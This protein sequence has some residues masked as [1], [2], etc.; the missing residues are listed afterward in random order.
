MSKLF[1]E[2]DRELLRHILRNGARVK[3][4]NTIAGE[5]LQRLRDLGVV[6]TQEH[7]YVRCAYKDD[8][9]F[10]DRE[11][12]DCPGRIELDSEDEDYYCPDCGQPIGD[13]ERKTVFVEYEVRLSPVGIE[14]YLERVL[15]SLEVVEAVEKTGMTAFEV[16][17]QGGI[18][19]KVVVPDYAEIR[20][21][22]VGLFFAEPTLYVIA[23]SI[24]EPVKTVLEERQYVQLADVLSSSVSAIQGILG[25]AAIPIPGRRSLREVEAKFDEMIARHGQRAWQFFE[26]DFVPVLI[27]HMTENPLLAQRY[28]EILR[29]LSGTVFGEFYVPIGGAGVADLRPIDKYRLMNQVFAGNATGDAKCYPKSALSYDDVIKVNYH[30]DSDPTEATM[31]IIYL[32]GDDV[33]STAWSAM[34]KL[35]Q[36]NG[37][38]KVII[39]PK[40]LLLE[41]I[42]ALEATHLLDV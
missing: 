1:P 18:F 32:A 42:D 36:T 16:K 21:R 6:V 5:V 20:Q 3:G 38:W 8:Y 10:L 14:E 7:T 28:L 12:L 13:I 29:R 30:L 23:S 4:E 41:L 40:Y 24:N 2:L 37:A 17:L 35:R 33:A 19:L 15:E 9:D 34:M 11:V 25:T 22:F 39:L 31:A 26:Q 27:R